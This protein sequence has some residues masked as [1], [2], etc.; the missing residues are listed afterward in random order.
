MATYTL[1]DLITEYGL[2]LDVKKPRWYGDYFFRAEN[3]K[4]D[5]SVSGTIFL[6]GEEHETKSFSSKEEMVLCYAPDEAD[7]SDVE[8]AGDQLPNPNGLDTD[9]SHYVKGVTKLFV[10]IKGVAKPAIFDHFS[11][12]DGQV[13]I[14]VIKEGETKA[15]FYLFP[16][17]KYVFPNKDEA[18]IQFDKEA[19]HFGISPSRT[20][21]SA[22]STKP[23]SRVPSKKTTEE[24]EYERSYHTQVDGQLVS[25]LAVPEK[26]KKEAQYDLAHAD[27][28]LRDEIV[29]ARENGYMVD[30]HTYISHRL[31]KETADSRISSAQKEIGRLEGIRRK[32]YF[33]R[34]DCG[35][36]MRDLHTVYLGDDDIDGLV[37]SWRHP[38]YGNAYYQSGILQGRDDLVLAL[39]RIISINRGEFDGYED[40]ISLYTAGKTT[41]TSTEVSFEG[42]ADE[43]L[44][45]LL[46]E[47][48][49][50]KRAHDIIKTIQGEQYEIITSDFRKNA[51]INGCAG[52]G[53]TMIMYHRLSYMA[54]NYQSY[55]GK[56]FNPKN[57]YIISPS[58]FFD[59]SNDELLTKLSIDSV[60]Q[61]P[62]YEQID[63]LLDIYCCKEGIVPFYGLAHYLESRG[64]SPVDF[65]TTNEFLRFESN[66]RTVVEE[67]RSFRQWTISLANYFLAL[68]GF[69]EIPLDILPKTVGDVHS[70]F[71]TSDYLYNDCFSKKGGTA[72]NRESRRLYSPQAITNISLENVFASLNQKHDKSSALFKQR[73]K[74]ITKNIDLLR[75]CLSPK[76]KTDVNSNVSTDIG[77][78]WTLLGNSAAF[79][80]M[81]AVLIAEKLIE[82]IVP[83]K[84]DSTS[85]ILRCLWVFR[86][87]Y[88]SQQA[89]YIKL[90]M[91]H[92]LSAKYGPAISEDALIFIDEFQN[93]SSFEIR[94]LKYA[95][96][97]PVFNLFGDYDQRIEEKG[98]DLKA[99]LTELLSPNAYNININYRNA[100]QI[101]EYINRTVHKNMQ[102]IGVQGTVIESTLDRCEFKIADRT[103]IICKDPKLAL[104]FLKRYIDAALINNSSVSKELVPEK[105]T[106]MTVLDC[107]GLEFDTV[108]VLDYGMT[109][110]EKY[111]AYTRALDTLVVI[112]DDLEAIKLAEEEAERK[113][114]EEERLRAKQAQELK[115]KQ[116]HISDLITVLKLLIDKKDSEEASAS[117]QQARKEAYR[118][119]YGSQLIDV[120]S[121]VVEKKEDEGKST[122][123][124]PAPDG[125]ASSEAMVPKKSHPNPSEEAPMTAQE[126]RLQEEFR[127]L[128]EYRSALERKEEETR[129]AEAA[130][131][132]KLYALAL[133][134]SE[135]D[136]ILQLTEAIVLFETIID[137]K[138]AVELIA[139]IRIRISQ[140]SAR[141][142]EQKASYRRNNLCQHCGGKFK[143][144]F[145][146]QC[147]VCGK[148]KDY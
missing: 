95:F 96:G 61:S 7:E 54:Y 83:S 17:T 6:N 130:R 143:G 74:K 13:R 42:K 73:L 148:K 77:E 90:F 116:K 101:T 49:A 46:I 68:H 80:K 89:D 97:S 103:A 141:S 78:F 102:S 64:S 126:L 1:K 36:S 129:R 35:A 118:H 32:P 8:E 94:C 2:P 92:S 31:R 127:K 11:E 123:D 20:I 87:M 93:Y 4:R 60:H 133:T 39:K 128:E 147:R 136:D 25:E 16:Q 3:L 81:L 104:F 106:L 29:A 135:T 82:C 52:S 58:S 112:P 53:K 108:Y 67:T 18:Q 69:N 10:N 140:I 21:V 88:S 70:L 115:K 120:L 110:N 100:K 125:A 56:Q 109:D 105:Y 19:R 134:K 45:R 76:T 63:N 48:R 65:F 139:K 142:E 14:Y 107:K 34:I 43:L 85:Y 117:T 40:E 144:L 27:E 132:E 79:E 47:S 28:E 131:K 5:G 37:V 33:A 55:L 57:V 121:Q 137:Y 30:D 113:R 59:S 41:N 26:K 145:S 22:F 114:K 50:D 75:C 86:D 51:V 138:N 44:T 71:T 146:K 84:K 24:H 62:F 38:E 122:V 9:M 124:I 98:S 15:G 72:D 66:V 111:V 23:K 12:V 91:L 119:K 99:N